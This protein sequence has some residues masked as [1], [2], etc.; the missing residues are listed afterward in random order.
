MIGFVEGVNYT[1]QK[2]IE[3]TSSKPNFTFMM[4]KNLKINMAVNFPFDNFLAYLDANTDEER[5]TYTNKFLQDVR[6]KVKDIPSRE[7]INP[8]QQTLDF[9]IMIVRNQHVYEFIN[10]SDTEIF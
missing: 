2:M 6:T 3:S 5:K 10:E 8:D 9:I 7:Y 1:K 4:P